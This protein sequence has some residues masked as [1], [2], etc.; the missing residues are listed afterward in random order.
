MRAITA[1]LL[2]TVPLGCPAGATMLHV[3]TVDAADVEGAVEV[4]ERVGAVC[5]RGAIDAAEARRLGAKMLSYEGREA[6]E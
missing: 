1:T 6:A 2:R 3:P 5:L 4:L